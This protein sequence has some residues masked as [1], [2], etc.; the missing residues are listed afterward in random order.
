MV[1]QPVQR[2]ARGIQR[3]LPGFEDLVGPKVW[4]DIL[5]QSPLEDHHILTN[6]HGTRWTAEFEKI[7]K[8]YG[9]DIKDKWNVANIRHPQTGGHPE[10]YHEW[11]W[12]QLQQIDIGARGDIQKFLE[13]FSEQIKQSV[14]EHPEML[15]DEFWEIIGNE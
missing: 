5:K 4:Q 11:V 6:K 10:A 13:L 9:L 1:A 2:G 12:E 8:D 14:E 15:L 7:L 3:I